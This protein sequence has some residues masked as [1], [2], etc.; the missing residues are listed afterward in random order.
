MWPA[1]NPDG[2]HNAGSS[3]SV[4]CKATRLLQFGLRESLNDAAEFRWRVASIP[5]ISEAAREQHEKRT[6]HFPDMTCR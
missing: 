6:K 1:E 4:R 3:R 2:I 5:L